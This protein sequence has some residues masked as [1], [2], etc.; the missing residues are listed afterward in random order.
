M[1]LFI[2]FEGGE[3]CGKST[4]SKILS[5]RLAQLALPSILIYEPGGTPLGE[6][7]RRLL[8]Q[9][10]DIPISPL[11]EL[12]LFNASRSQLILEVIQPALKEGKIIICDRFTDSTVA[13]QH[14]GRGLDEKM[15][16]RVNEIASQGLKP[17]LTI[18]LDI[19]PES[20]LA[21]KKDGARDR[22][23]QEERAFYQKIRNGFLEIASNEPQ[24]WL[25]IDA[26]L[27]K[28][29]ISSL[30]WTRFSNLLKR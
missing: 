11:T 29:I 17:D 5:R 1:S 2:T 3:G 15:V 9:S 23:M 12:M 26:C 14:Y 10:S 30:I 7:V 19:R 25:V 28:K 6:K 4:Q 20:G 22:F 16:N 13:Y 21:R 27:P 8:K 18:L 24:R